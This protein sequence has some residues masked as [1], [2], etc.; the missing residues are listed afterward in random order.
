MPIFESVCESENCDLRGLIVDDFY[1]HYDDPAKLCEWCGQCRTRLPSTFASPFM[2]EMSRR[3]VDKSLDDGHREDLGHWMWRT[4]SSV[5]GK[6]EPVYVDTWQKQAEICRAEG[7]ANPRDFDT[8]TEVSEDG[9]RFQ[10][11]TATLQDLKEAEH[12]VAQVAKP[13]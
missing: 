11:T 3:Y 13:E 5:S 8:N 12:K 4:K 10:K 7:L 6:P 9:R 2:G 1:R